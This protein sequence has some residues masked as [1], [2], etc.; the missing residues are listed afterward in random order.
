MNKV[1]MFGEY[2]PKKISGYIKSCGIKIPVELNKDNILL[3]GFNQIHTDHIS[4]KSSQAFG[5]KLD[6]I[7]DDTCIR[8]CIALAVGKN[9]DKNVNKKLYTN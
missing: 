7:G 6:K 2:T 4:N 1:I 5:K 9:I 3:C 8:Y